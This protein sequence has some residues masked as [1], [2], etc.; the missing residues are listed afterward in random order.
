MSECRFEAQA[1]MLEREF[2]RGID[3][4]LIVEVQGY[5]E[6]HVEEGTSTIP[7][8]TSLKILSELQA[9]E[10]TPK[11]LMAFSLFPSIHVAWSDGNLA[12]Q[13]KEAILKAAESTGVISGSP[14]YG[15]LNSWLNKK[16]APELFSAWKDF[17][18]A[19]RPALSETAFQE[20]RDAASNRARNVAETAGGILG[21]FK[22]SSTEE[23]ALKELEQAFASAAQ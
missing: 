20:L 18:V 19:I 6:Q 11:T 21:V 23:K 4:E 14:A 13:E 1:E 17:V 9:A 2:Y 22:I 12:D 3:R 10:I 16:P 7:G 15:L 8:F 5:I